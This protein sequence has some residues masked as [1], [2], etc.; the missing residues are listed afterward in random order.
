MKI[1]KKRS[2]DAKIGPYEATVYDVFQALILLLFVTK[3]NTLLFW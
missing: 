2:Y 3:N 1:C